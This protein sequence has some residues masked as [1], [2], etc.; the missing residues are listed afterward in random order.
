[1]H[2]P[3]ATLA[4]PLLCCAYY[5]AELYLPGRMKR[6]AQVALF[7]LAGILF[8]IH[9]PPALNFGR[10]EALMLDNFRRDVRSGMPREKILDIYS[11][12]L[13]LSREKLNKGLQELRA[14]GVE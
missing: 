5:V 3:S 12:Q 9:I 2:P 6:A 7:S 4:T 11:D 10:G 13:V 8:L 1:L 14:A